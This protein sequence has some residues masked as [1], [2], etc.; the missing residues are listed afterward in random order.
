MKL[1]RAIQEFLA[2]GR[3]YLSPA[4]LAAYESDLGRLAALVSPDSVLGF[5]PD[6]IRAYF[7]GLSHQ[8]RRMA[9]LYRKHSALHEFSRWGVRKGLWLKNPMEDIQRPPKPQ[10]LPRPFS[11]E[12]MRRIM[13]LELAPIERV[14]RAVL[15]YTGL[16]VSPICAIK[17][18]DLSFDEIRYPNGVTFPGT[19]RTTGK[20]SKPLVTP[21]HPALKE[22]LFGF[23]LEHTD[24]KG[25]S[26]LLR[27]PRK[28]QS[29]SVGRPYTRRMIE[30]LTHQWGTR[31]EVPNCL[32]HR[33][34]HTFAT[35]LLRQ[36]TDIR[37][38]QILL[39]HADLGT[40]AIYTRVVDAQTGEA[41]LR[42]PS[43]WKEREK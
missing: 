39:G 10:H 24:M 26:P 7:L 33:F 27:Q 11:P 17:V 8:N 20:G 22:L 42:L 36:G 15:Y 35:D 4:T 28:K 29:R 43:E 2:D 34:R 5:T 23:A 41:V 1:S 32:P 25:Q 30:R 19:I 37:V 6:V 12:E 40:T 13:Q 38:I 3:T 16:R 9:T 18:G 31:A 21:M 14:I